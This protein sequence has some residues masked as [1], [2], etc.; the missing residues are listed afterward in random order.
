MPQHK[1]VSLKESGPDVHA[2]AFRFNMPSKPMQPP[3]G[4]SM[5][6]PKEVPKTESPVVPV[7]APGAPGKQA[8]TAP[9]PAAASAPSTNSS[10]GSMQ[11]FDWDKVTK[12]PIPEDDAMH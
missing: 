7:P 5:S 1:P 8:A 6:S 2:I 10:A 9:M 11:G 3:P 4:P 12:V